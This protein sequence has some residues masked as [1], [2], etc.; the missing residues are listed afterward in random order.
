[1]HSYYN[2]TNYQDV[3]CLYHSS[4]L[5]NQST[6]PMVMPAIPSLNLHVQHKYS[7]LPIAIEGGGNP[8]QVCP[9]SQTVTRKSLLTQ[10][11]RQ[12]NKQKYFFTKSRLDNVISRFLK[13]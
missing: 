2:V 5:D 7:S 9:E 4:P 13:A 6:S 1:M 10:A 3:Y 11:K 12:Q 8:S